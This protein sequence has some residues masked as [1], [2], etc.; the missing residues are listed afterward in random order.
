MI[1]S[2]SPPYGEAQIGENLDFTSP[3]K[4]NLI[5]VTK[6]FYNKKINM[7]IVK[8]TDD[9]VDAMYKEIK[10]EHSGVELIDL[11]KLEKA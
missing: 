11:I 7:L 4:I 9:S 6:E 8:L 10:E 1:I 3:E 2:D 5:E